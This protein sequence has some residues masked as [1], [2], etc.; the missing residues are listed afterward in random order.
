[1]AVAVVIVFL[2]SARQ[3]EGSARKL[4]WRNMIDLIG[5]ASKSF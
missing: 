3:G 4:H 5:I 2:P 1:M